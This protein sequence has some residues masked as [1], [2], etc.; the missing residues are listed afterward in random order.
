MLNVCRNNEFMD[1][2]KRVFGSNLDK[3]LYV[4]SCLFVREK[5]ECWEEGLLV[6]SGEKLV[7]ISGKEVGNIED[8]ETTKNLLI[9][10]ENM[11]DVYVD[12]IEQ[13]QKAFLIEE[14]RSGSYLEK[15]RMKTSNGTEIVRYLKDSSYEKE[16]DGCA[17]L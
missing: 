16:E 4:E 5:S 2:F 15:W 10:I 12:D 17:Y 8:I 6:N 13:W 1:L 14:Y 3:H 9:D 11:V 7:D